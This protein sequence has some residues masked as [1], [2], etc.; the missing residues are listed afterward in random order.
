MALIPKSYKNIY[1]TVLLL[2]GLKTEIEIEEEKEIDTINPDIIN[3]LVTFDD[4]T[5]REFLEYKLKPFA[6]LVESR[7]KPKVFNHVAGAIIRR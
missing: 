4:Q 1:D 5:Q 3:I 6:K 7:I 2:I